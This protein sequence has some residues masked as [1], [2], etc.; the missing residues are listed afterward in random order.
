MEGS[1]V[2]ISADPIERRTVVFLFQRFMG[3][4]YAE[5]YELSPYSII[6]QKT[7]AIYEYEPEWRW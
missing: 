2:A 4:R 5:A 3:D 1:H 7:N 6:V